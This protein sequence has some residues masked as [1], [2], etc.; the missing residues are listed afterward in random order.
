[1]S[2]RLPIACRL[3]LF[4]LSGIALVACAPKPE[5]R[6]Y[7][8]NL[9]VER[10]PGVPAPNVALALAGKLVGRSDAAGRARLELYGFEGGAVSIDVQCP[11]GSEP[12]APLHARLLTF[13]QGATPTLHALCTPKN[14]RTAVVVRATRG[15]HLPVVYH[16]KTLGVTDGE[17]VAHI[18][19]EGRPGD[20]FELTLDTALRPELRPQNP[21]ASFAIVADDSVTSY[22]TEFSVKA[23]DP[24]RHSRNHGALRGPVRIR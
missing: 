9:L 11:A 5:Q 22:D 16:A 4:A 14:R 18:V 24:A 21:G 6:S 1:M 7:A 8:V 15:S 13:M 10:E 3:A 19:L 23:Q 20:A 17:G 2:T 12:P